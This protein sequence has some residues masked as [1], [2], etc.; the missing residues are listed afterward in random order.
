LKIDLKIKNKNTIIFLIS[1]G[2]S[3]FMW[4]LI[5]LSK[6]YEVEISLPV[7]YI[8]MPKNMTVNQSADSVIRL[9]LTDNGFDLLSNS[10]TSPFRS[11]TL[12]L[13]TFKKKRITD[14]KTK[15]YVLCYSLEKELKKT[16]NNPSEINQIKPDSLVMVFENLAS[17]K[18][19]II[20]KIHTELAPQYQLSEDINISPDSILIFGVKDDLSKISQI[21]TEEKEFKKVNKNIRTKLKLIIPQHITSQKN[22]T[23]LNIKVEKYTESELTIPIEIDFY[24]KD[25]IKIFPRDIHLKFAVSLEN[26]HKIKPDQFRVIGIRDSIVPGRI[27]LI[28]DKQAENIR[29]LDYSPKMAEFILLK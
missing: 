23:E 11:M 25:S 17:R 7:S 1:I 27:D 20:P 9:K 18:I 6:D 26:Y 5:K 10:I 13:N 29:V 2:I 15:Y 28:L 16:F 19:A 22:H 8:N 12:D 4:L 14:N 24:H 21:Y 3:T